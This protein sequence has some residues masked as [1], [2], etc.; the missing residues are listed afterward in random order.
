MSA[1]RASF[2]AASGSRASADVN[3]VEPAPPLTM[4]ELHSTAVSGEITAYTSSMAR[5]SSSSRCIVARFAPSNSC[6]TSAPSVAVSSMITVS[7]PNCSWMA[8]L[9]SATCE[10][11]FR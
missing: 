1:V 9:S 11:G 5:S 2:P 10:S 4:P 7:P 8:T 6:E 3:A